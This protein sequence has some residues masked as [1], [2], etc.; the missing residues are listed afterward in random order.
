[1]Y[2]NF[3]GWWWPALETLTDTGWTAVE[4]SWSSNNRELSLYVNDIYQG[5]VVVD[6]SSAALDEVRLGAIGLDQGI[7]GKLLLDDFNSRRY[8]YLGLIDTPDID[9]PEPADEEDWAE[10]VYACEGEQAHAVTSVSDDS[11][12]NT[13]TQSSVTLSK[14]LL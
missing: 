8:T 1:M 10:R 11:L 4:I 9:L 5:K 14:Q 3:D 2:H 12:T 13:Y 7:G 6:E